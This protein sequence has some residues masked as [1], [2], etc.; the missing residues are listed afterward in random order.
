MSH[1]C[2]A[3]G[4]R[5]SVPPEMLM[6]LSHWRKVPKRIQLAV[7]RGYRPGQ[8]DDKRPSADWHAAADAAIGYVALLEGKAISKR[9]SDVLRKLGYLT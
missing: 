2:H 4:C 8:C 3:T 6:C 5:K 1:S 7:W 9:Q